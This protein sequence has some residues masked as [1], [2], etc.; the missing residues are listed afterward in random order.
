MSTPIALTQGQ[1][2][3]VIA[4]VAVVTAISLLAIGL[5]IVAR[6]CKSGPG[7]RAD[8]YV[9]A[10][11]LVSII[12]EVARSRLSDHVSKVDLADRLDPDH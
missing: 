11:A 8:D 5:R 6:H 4:S 10:L 12:L 3:T 1:G 7:L 2:T 9:N